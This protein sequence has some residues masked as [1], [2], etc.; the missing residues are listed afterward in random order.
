MR[1]FYL[2]DPLPEFRHPHV[3]VTVLSP[4]RMLAQRICDRFCA[5]IPAD[6]ACRSKRHPL[7][8]QF[9]ADH[10]GASD[11]PVTADEPASEEI[12]DV[13]P[14]CVT[15]VS[16]TGGCGRKPEQFLSRHRDCL[17]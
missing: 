6:T 11:F 15:D 13:P 14:V 3:P 9:S 1:P 2:S 17:V 4:D 8:R 5:V 10:S 12:Q 7:I 16:Y